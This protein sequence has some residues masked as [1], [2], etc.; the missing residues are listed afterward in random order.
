MSFVETDVRGSARTVA[1]SLVYKP[2]FEILWAQIDALCCQVDAIFIVNNGEESDLRRIESRYFGEKKVIL[3]QLPCN[4]GVA[5]GFNAGIVAAQE[6]SPEFILLMDQDSVPEAGMVDGLVRVHFE[7]A[8][9]G[10]KTFAVG[11]R[12][13]SHKSSDDC[14]LIR[15]RSNVIEA[16]SISDKNGAVEECSYLISS[17]CLVNAAAAARI[18][19]MLEDLFIDLVDIEWGLR[20]KSMGYVCLLE[21]KVVLNHSIGE[22]KRTV[23]FMFKERLLTMHHPF[24]YY[25]MWRNAILLARL[26]YIPSCFSRYL[27]AGRIKH[28]LISI[29]A[30][31][32]KLNL[33]YYSVLGV[34]HG[35]IGRSGGLKPKL[36]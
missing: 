28:L 2:N 4:V 19:G 10:V 1:V 24:R 22:Y 11:P 20:A 12:Y 16:L 9:L 21:P 13:V 25:Y 30:C 18:G 26:E 14:C 17:G 32:Q 3:K 34:V 5:A 8:R 29:T 36:K 31:D 15:I 7:R 33:L 23:R 35:L 6:L 27:I